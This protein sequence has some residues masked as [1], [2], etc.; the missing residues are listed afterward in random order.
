[1]TR[2][3]L[4]AERAR[5]RED[6]W[7]VPQITLPETLVA[8]ARDVEHRL[9]AVVKRQDLL[10]GIHNPFG[11]H[12]CLSDAWTFLDIAENA[13]LLDLVEDALGPDLV[14]WDS[15]LYVDLTAYSAQESRYWPLDPLSGTIVF[16]DLERANVTLVDV[17]RLAA[18]FAHLPL[19]VGAHY[20]I[21]YGSG[22]SLYNRDPRFEPNRAAM[23]ARPLVNYT[24]R[25][26]WLVRGEDRAGSDFV[27]GFSP[28]AVR[29]AGVAQHETSSQPIGSNVIR[30]GEQSCPS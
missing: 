20:V 10:S 22:S 15:E 18:V 12:A 16:L 24:T 4:P 1:M 21:R 9:A 17:T 11:R 5:Y 25:P 7:V 2:R 3:L 8:P 26:I 28:P 13:V 27:T 14:L 19:R 29:W 30:G 23:E 6:G